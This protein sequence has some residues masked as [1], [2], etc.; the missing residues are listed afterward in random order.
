MYTD[1]SF[2]LSLLYFG[3]TEIQVHFESMQL[4]AFEVCRHLSIPMSHTV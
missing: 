2:S 1:K 4:K 3:R